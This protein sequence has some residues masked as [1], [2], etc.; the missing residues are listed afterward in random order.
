MISL[1][2]TAIQQV[3]DP[4]ATAGGTTAEE[5]DTLGYDYATILVL[6]GNLASNATAFEVQE[7]DTSGSGFALITGADYDGGTD[8]DGSTASLPAAASDDDKVFVFEIDLK[9]RKRYI[10][11]VVTIGGSG[12]AVGCVAILSRAAESPTTTAERSL[13]SSLGGVIRA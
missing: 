2:N 5:I 4:I 13:A 10:K 12:S 11:P 6:V 8:I 1:Q 3:I 9:A 7:S